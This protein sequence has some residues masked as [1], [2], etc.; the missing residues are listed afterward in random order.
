MGIRVPMIKRRVYLIYLND[1]AITHT[2]THA[3]IAY[4]R[5][6]FKERITLAPVTSN[7]C[8]ATNSVQFV[9]KKKIQAAV[10]LRLSQSRFCG[11]TISLVQLADPCV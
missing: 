7:A 5:D 3:R 10:S 9:T 4:L 8:D 11:K 6:P 2:H 1:R